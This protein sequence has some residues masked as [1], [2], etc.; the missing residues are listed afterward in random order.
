MEG[1]KKSMKTHAQHWDLCSYEDR[2]F[3]D[4]ECR[5]CGALM[6]RVDH[7]HARQWTCSRPYDFAHQ[8][9][10]PFTTFGAWAFDEI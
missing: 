10:K 6:M 1:V 8:I 7:G 9:Q 3:I 4:V 5:T 2:T